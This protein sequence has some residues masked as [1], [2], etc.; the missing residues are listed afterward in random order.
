VALSLAACADPVSELSEVYYRGPGQRVLCTVGIDDGRSSDDGVDAGLDRARDDGLVVQL[1]AHVPGRTIP[2]ARI[3]R[4]LAGARDRGLAHFTYDDFAAGVPAAAGIALSFDD[5]STTEWAQ[6]A[7]LLDAYG[8]RVTFFLSYYDIYT[9]AQRETVRDLAA[10]GH[11]IGNHTVRH[12]RGPDYAERHGLEGY[13][14]DEVRPAD[15]ALRADG[16]AP[17]AF[18][19]PFGARTSELDRAILDEYALVRSVTFS[20]DGLFVVDPC[21]E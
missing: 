20:R 10:R 14:R 4:V 2:V 11:A 13:L 7:D 17:V 8:A 12:L 18:A 5:A 16:H 6:I 21:P 3:E 15:Q 1:Y 19:Y 9:P